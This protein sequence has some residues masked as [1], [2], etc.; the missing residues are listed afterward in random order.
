MA[1][2]CIIAIALSVLSIAKVDLSHGL[3]SLAQRTPPVYASSATL[4]VTQSGFPWGS[5]VQLY[6]SSGSK[7][8]TAS[9]VPSGDLNRLTALANLYVQ[10]ANSDV[11]RSIVARHA[12]KGGQLISATQNY[13]FSP[14]YYSSALPIVTING[15]GTTRGNAILTTQAGANALRAYLKR[16]QNAAGIRD[17]QRVVL[18]EIQQPRLVTVMNPIKKTIPVVVFL[19]VMMAVV[20]LAFVLENVRPRTSEM[21]AVRQDVE[22]VVDAARRTA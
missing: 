15:T 1:G 16:Q 21:T 22:P 9:L 4:L 2:G 19:T 7:T 18:Q 11:I 5:A 14:S 10:L 17:P 3:P 6:S 8:S 12:P 20:G 13:S